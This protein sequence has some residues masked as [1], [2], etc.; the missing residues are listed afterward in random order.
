M[1]FHVGQKVICINDRPKPGQRWGNGHETS[2]QAGVIYTVREIVP[3]DPIAGLKEALRFVEI[4][5]RLDEYPR[6]SGRALVEVN[7]RASR[8]FP[9]LTTNIDVFLEMPA[10]VRVTWREDVE[11][12]TFV[13]AFHWVVEAGEIGNGQ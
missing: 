4:V 8:F 3:R 9:V 1:H 6:G 7:F 12:Y 10:R 2:V 13:D 5:N 11:H